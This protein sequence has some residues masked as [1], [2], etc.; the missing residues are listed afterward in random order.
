VEAADRKGAQGPWFVVC[1]LGLCEERHCR[2]A[3]HFS[4]DAE[5]HPAATGRALKEAALDVEGGG[6][7]EGSGAEVAELM[8]HSQAA[9]SMPVIA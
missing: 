3:R 7:V 1:R 9:S 2:A 5:A 4:E 6:F 8:R